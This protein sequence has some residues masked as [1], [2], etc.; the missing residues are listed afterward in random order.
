MKWYV[1]SSLIPFTMRTSLA[2]KNKKQKQKN[3]NLALSSGKMM[4]R[5]HIIPVIYCY[6]DSVYGFVKCLR[7]RSPIAPRSSLL[8]DDK[9]TFTFEK[10]VW[11][12]MPAILI[13]TIGQIDLSFNFILDFYLLSYGGTLWSAILLNYLILI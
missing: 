4:R 6:F 13:I 11:N 12:W 8:N 3:G 7:V 10:I 1:H 5:S 9:H 2:R